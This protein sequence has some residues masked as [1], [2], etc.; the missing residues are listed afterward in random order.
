V[1]DI[2]NFAVIGLVRH[3]PIEFGSRFVTRRVRIEIRSKDEFWGRAFHVEW[4]DQFPG[5]ELIS[6][7]QGGF[8]S[9][10]EWI[11]DLASVATLTFSRVVVA[12]ESPERRRWFSVLS[13]RR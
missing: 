2:L 12:P 4:N 9:E 5:R 3:R 13:G 7:G 10:P 11:D 6:D 1:F 8:L